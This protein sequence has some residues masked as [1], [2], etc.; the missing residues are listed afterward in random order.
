MISTHFGGSMMRA[1]LVA[2]L[3]ALVLQ[4]NT[5]FAQQQG[6]PQA[7]A[8]LWRARYCGN[9]HGSQAEGAYGPDLAGGRGLT[10]EQVKRA[11]RRPWGVMPAY[12][13]TQLSDQQIADVLA[14]LQSRPKVDQPGEWHWPAV[15][16]SAP[17]GQRL[18]MNTAGCGQCHE[19]EN[20]WGRMWLGENAKHVDYEYFKRMVYNHTEK[21]PAGGMGNFNPHR[22]P[23]FMVRELY[24]FHVTTYNITVTNRGTKDVGLDVEGLTVFVRVPSGTKVVSGTGPGYAGVQ[25]FASLGLQP[26]QGRAEHPNEQGVV[27]RPAL[28]YS[29][30]AIVWRIPK[31]LAAD[32]VDLSFAIEGPPSAE[33]FKGFDGSA[34]HW[35][36]PG[37]TEFGRKL[38][39]FDTRLPDVG[40]HERLGVPR[41]PTASR[42]AA[43]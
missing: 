37:R 10:F 23:E 30:D 22:V 16:D 39:Y 20:K 2:S 36:K 42:G 27:I 40:D 43:R 21:Y 38:A 15:P 14:F 34:M 11:I 32:K 4:T 19:P 28:D 31:L 1:F 7:G 26:A 24:K 9:C 17:L 35:E 8:S 25:T 13:E 12:A 41:L 18:Y 5:A 29:G 3:F 6:D 33:L